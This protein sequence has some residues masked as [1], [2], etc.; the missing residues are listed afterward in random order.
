MK[1][2]DSIDIAKGLAILL[3]VL[4]HSQFSDYGV[5]F[6]NMMHMPLFFFFSG[7]CFKEKYLEDFPAFIHQRIKGL[8]VPFV[9]WS[10]FFLILHNTFYH[11]NI[12]NNYFGFRGECS[13]LLNFNEFIVNALR[14]VFTMNGNGL[15]L[16]GYWFLKALFITSI[17]C[18]IFI[19]I[20]G[21]KVKYVIPLFIAFSIILTCDEVEYLI[22]RLYGRCSL[23]TAV[24]LT[25]YCYNKSGAKYECNPIII[26]VSLCLCLIGA[27]YYPM[28]MGDP[29]GAMIN[30]ILYF[31]TAVM[32]VL[33][34]FSIS[35]LIEKTRLLK[36][37]FVFTGKNTMTVLTWHLLCFKIVSLIIIKIYDY[38]I[39]HL[40]EFPVMEYQTD[41][42]W[43]L[44]Y[45]IAGFGIPITMKF[46]QISLSHHLIH[47]NR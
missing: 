11:L 36:S 1:R 25:G 13:H 2:D 47:K 34:L 24:F 31:I 26:P 33:M 5:A 14:I 21:T 20:L 39:I 40:A 35:K 37:F 44:L 15:L 23:A 17:I 16:G 27:Y 6:I 19:K 30:Y 45:L 32:G 10:L 7:Y 8:Y 42:G 29:R 28:K 43:W 18:F 41:L 4:S 3:L 12:Y 9:K 22:L 38:P 46:F